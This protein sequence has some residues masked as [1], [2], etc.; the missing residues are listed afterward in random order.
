M[1]KKIGTIL[2]LMSFFTTLVLSV[3]VFTTYKIYSAP[4]DSITLSFGNEVTKKDLPVIHTASNGQSKVDVKTQHKL[5]K[6]DKF[7]YEVN[8]PENQKIRR[9]RL[10]FP[11]AERNVIIKEIR[12]HHG[13]RSTDIP[14]NT[15]KKQEGFHLVNNRNRLELQIRDKYAFLDVPQKYIYTSDFGNIYYLF[16][17]FFIVVI[18]SSVVVFCFKRTGF[19]YFTVDNITTSLMVIS[20]FLPAPIYNISLISLAVLNIR[21]ISWK[22]IKSQWTNIFILVFFF[23]YLLNNLL[24]SEEGL[25]DMSVIERFLPFFILTLLLPN[26]SRRRYLTLFVIS[27]LVLGFVFVITSFFD[28][29]I[30]SN[31]ELLSFNL[32]TK[33]LHPVYFSYLLFFSICYVSIKYEGLKKHFL[34]FILF[35]FLVF[36]GSKMV[37]ILAIIVVIHDLLRN[38]KG[39]ILILPI[40]GIIMFFSPLIKRF[41][42]IY[43]IDDLSI[44][45]EEH[46]SS[47]NDD[48]VN[49][50]TLRLLLARET[51]KTMN[52]KDYLF[53]KGVSRSTDEVLR[54]RLD[55]IGLKNHLN[56]NPHNQ[57]IDTFWRGGL[58]TL[59]VLIFIPLSSI[60]NG[61]KRKDRLSVLFSC[62]MLFVMGSEVIFGR[63]N[64]IYFFTLVLLILNNTKLNFKER[65]EIT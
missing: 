47:P 61:V 55:K 48:R 38:R 35:A 3:Y 7:L 45:S 65:F 62:F 29:Y 41:E 8:L 60:I 52:Y 49:G 40:V 17:A 44:L 64:G 13:N 18:L 43:S 33:Y 27:S 25:N 16:I 20:V 59:I 32:F 63:V 36:S 15:I 28:M 2:F 34:Q 11:F 54:Y 46:I 39:L 56:F 5:Q 10:Y 53:G 4:I 1:I 50:L 24:I 57:Y 30:H 51:L 31:S 12:L 19:G 26:L 37:F 14:L 9:I 21:K 23:L 22:S 58:I 42:E 6:K